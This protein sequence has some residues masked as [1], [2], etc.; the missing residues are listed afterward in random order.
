MVELTISRGEN[1]KQNFSRIG[2]DLK[3][4]TD[5]KEWNHISCQSN[6]TQNNNVDDD[7]PDNHIT[8]SD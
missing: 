1:K 6:I 4:Q 3:D 8:N 7:N 5:T 2:D